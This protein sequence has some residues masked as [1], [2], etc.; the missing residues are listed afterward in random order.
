MGGMQPGCQ[1]R[2]TAS[3]R[4]FR[5]GKKAY[6]LGALEMSTTLQ[7][8]PPF[9][10]YSVVVWSEGVSL[11]FGG[12]RGERIKASTPQRSQS[13]FGGCDFEMAFVGVVRKA[14]R[15]VAHWQGTSPVD[16]PRGRPPHPLTPPPVGVAAII[17]GVFPRSCPFSPPHVE[18]RGVLTSHPPHTRKP[19]S[20]KETPCACVTLGFEGLPWA[21]CF[22][23]ETPRNP[24]L[25]GG[26]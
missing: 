23:T 6:N 18:G 7:P 1:P 22:F 13:N 24:R 3:P 12:P 21:G 17:C 11:G 15:G 16:A 4:G 10:V 8:S 9:Y 25:L 2:P 20:G 26:G 19:Q 5:V 14:A